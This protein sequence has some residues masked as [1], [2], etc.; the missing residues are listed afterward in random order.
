M[1]GL[2]NYE[3]EGL[4]KELA[5]MPLKCNT[6]WGV[7]YILLDSPGFMGKKGGEQYDTV[8]NLF[9][10]IKYECK[11]ETGKGCLLR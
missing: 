9:Y 1:E 5:L 11:T 6:L 4:L 3:N 10:R 8:I 2:I 7:E